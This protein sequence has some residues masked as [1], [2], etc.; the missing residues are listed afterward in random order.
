MSS[1]YG[2][3]YSERNAFLNL[4][5]G[6]VEFERAGTI[7]FVQ[8]LLLSFMYACLL[9]KWPQRKETRLLYVLV[10]VA[11][12]SFNIPYLLMGGRIVLLLPLILLVLRGRSLKWSKQKMARLLAGGLIATVLIGGSVALMI[13]Q[14][15][16]HQDLALRDLTSK[17]AD[18][19][20]TGTHPASL[21]PRILEE[22]VMKFDSISWGALLVELV[23]V[24]VAGWQPYWGAFAAS[25]PRQLMPSKPVPG[26][27]DG[28][29]QGVPSRLVPRMISSNSLSY[30]VQV[31]PA[32]IT[33]W[34]FGY[35]SLIVMILCNVLYLLFVNSLLISTSIIP[36][37]LALFLIGIPGFSRL[38]ASPDTLLSNLQRAI[39]IYLLLSLALLLPTLFARKSA[40][41]NQ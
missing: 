21:A 30:N 13:G 24:D 27:M 18:I 41:I 14:Y 40:I 16:V 25:V 38:F 19:F 36:K 11:I 8:T 17:S 5:S 39:L 31:S 34:E 37:S 35:G 1:V 2:S 7:S 4:A 9:S 12:A 3:S 20:E 6:T 10:L 23:G 26:S 15:R 28:T 32:A 22:I 33:L 29:Y